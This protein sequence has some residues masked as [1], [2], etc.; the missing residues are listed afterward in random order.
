V[1]VDSE[2]FHEGRGAGKSTT[3]G[4]SLEKECL[5]KMAKISVRG[6]TIFRAVLIAKGWLLIGA[7]QEAK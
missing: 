1:N 6:V 7:N 2:R 5:E 3:P 4:G